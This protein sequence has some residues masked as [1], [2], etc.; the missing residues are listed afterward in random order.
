MKII[1]RAAVGV[2]IESSVRRAKQTVQR[3]LQLIPLSDLETQTLKAYTA[4]YILQK[5]AFLGARL[6]KSP[7]WRVTR[8]IPPVPQVVRWDERKEELAEQCFQLGAQVDLNDQ[9]YTHSQLRSLANQISLAYL[10]NPDANPDEFNRNIHKVVD[11]WTQ[12]NQTS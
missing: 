12:R 5:E 2:V 1:E 6:K 9:I 11:F 7:S 8:F 10:K 4:A 3:V